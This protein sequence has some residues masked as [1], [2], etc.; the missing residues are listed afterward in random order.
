MKK[1]IAEYGLA[2]E[3]VIPFPHLEAVAGGGAPNA[4][5]LPRSYFGLGLKRVVDALFSL[6]VLVFGLP[7]IC[8]S[9]H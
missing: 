9:R 5:T 8:S 1:I 2:D 3:K 4:L 7:F 6:F